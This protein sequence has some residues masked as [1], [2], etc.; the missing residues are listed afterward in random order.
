MADKIHYEM[1]GAPRS[2]GYSTKSDLIKHLEGFG[3]IKDDMSG[4]GYGTSPGDA[5][6]LLLT[7]SYDSK[8]SKM[9]KAQKLGIRILTYEDLMKEL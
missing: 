7:D 4:E 3:Y 9:Y 2:S 8:S 1:T 6:E 5:C